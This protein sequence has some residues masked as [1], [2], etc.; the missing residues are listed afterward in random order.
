LAK[1]ALGR[2]D[3]AG[4][5]GHLRSAADQAL[6]GGRLDLLVELEELCAERRR[7]PVLE[8][9][10]SRHAEAIHDPAARIALEHRRASLL[11]D[12][13]GD[14]QA[15]LRVASAALARAPADTALCVLMVRAAAAT[16]DT[17]RSAEAVGRLLALSEAAL[18]TPAELITLAEELSD[19]G[20]SWALAQRAAA[21]A[22]VPADRERALRIAAKWAAEAGRLDEAVA[23]L[24]ALRREGAADAAELWRLASLHAARGR[25][26]EAAQLLADALTMFVA[27][28]RSGPPQGDAVAT[29]LEELRTTVSESQDPRP[30]AEGLVA[31]GTLTAD[32]RHAAAYFREGAILWRELEE[33]TRAVDALHRAFAVRPGDPLIMADL[34]VL[35]REQQD[36]VGLLQAY[37]THVEQLPEPARGPIYELMARLCQAELG[38][39]VRAQVYA[40]L[41]R[42]SGAELGGDAQPRRSSSKAE[43]ALLKRTLE[44]MPLD[45][46]Q[47][48]AELLYQLGEAH[49]S[50]GQRELAEDLYLKA[51]DLDSDHAPTLRRLIEHYWSARDL[52]GV[53]ELAAELERLDALLVEKTPVSSLARVAVARAFSGEEEGARVLLASLG[54]RGAVPLAG[55]LADLTKDSADPAGLISLAERLCK[56]PGPSF[57]A[58]QA[59]LLQRGEPALLRLLSPLGARKR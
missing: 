27:D 37:G 28:P 51:I 24:E 58:V 59:A 53:N 14:A 12:P 5:D 18:P 4:A 9:L 32:D 3:E 1:I 36:L 45:Q 23:H 26:H 6:R 21:L 15:A 25:S 52:N 11:L 19:P 8:H 31:A 44:E 2:G 30:L 33:L 35:L 40:D 47:R 50:L 41:A 57:E 48:R 55:A 49:L 17:S 29:I 16:G 46:P 43:I 56:P 38:D 22:A 10:L 7:F 39:E 54:P 13:I 20:T 42:A 34:D